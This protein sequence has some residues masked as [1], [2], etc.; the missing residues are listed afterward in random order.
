MIDV[1]ELVGR[2]VTLPE[3][4]YQYGVGSLRLRIDRVDLARPVMEGGERWYWV[5]G[6]QVSGS[7]EE[8]RP[9]VV[10]VRGCRLSG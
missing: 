10:L 9:R 8:V 2:V 6:V 4:D 5:E 3:P 7:G 1:S